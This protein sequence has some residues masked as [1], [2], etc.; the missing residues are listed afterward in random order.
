MFLGRIAV[1]DRRVDALDEVA[2]A[3]IVVVV[4]AGAGIV[5]VVRLDIA[6]VEG[7]HLA[8]AY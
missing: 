7:N 6:A 1:V 3:S 4:D 5:V 8:M 2:A